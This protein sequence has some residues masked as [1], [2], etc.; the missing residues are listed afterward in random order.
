MRL[1]V[2]GCRATLGLEFLDPLLMAYPRLEAHG[3]EIPGP[4]LLQMAS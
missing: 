1:V 3:C 4:E 2:G